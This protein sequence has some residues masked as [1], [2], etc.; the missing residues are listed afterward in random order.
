MVFG[1]RPFR[2]AKLDDPLFH[3]LLQNPLQFWLAHPVTKRRI[4]DKT[5][6]SESIDILT[7]MLLVNPEKRLSLKEIKAHKFVQISQYDHEKL[8]ESKMVNQML[9]KAR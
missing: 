1:C 7:R 3:Q 8:S 4:E 9:A 5:V 2:E 6:S